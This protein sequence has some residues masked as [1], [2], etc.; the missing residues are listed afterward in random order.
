MKNKKLIII[1]LLVV[2]LA[3]A[4]SN[5]NNDKKQEEVSKNIMF[6]NVGICE[7]LKGNV[8]EI[9][10]LHSSY[11]IILSSVTTITTDLPRTENIYLVLT[12]NGK[13]Y[14]L[15]DSEEPK[16][17]NG[18]TCQVIEHDIEIDKLFLM[19]DS[20]LAMTK[21]NQIYNINIYTNGNQFTTNVTN[22]FGSV[23]DIKTIYIDGD[24]LIYVLRNNGSMYYIA[25][26]DSNKQQYSVTIDSYVKS[27][28]DNLIGS[29]NNKYAFYPVN[30]DNVIIGS[31]YSRDSLV[32]KYN[33]Y[34]FTNIESSYSENAKSSIEYAIDIDKN[35]YAKLVNDNN[36]NEYSLIINSDKINGNVQQFFGN[37]LITNS[38]IYIID[39]KEK[40]FLDEETIY[41]LNDLSTKFSNISDLTNG[42]IETMTYKTTS[43]NEYQISGIM[44]KDNGIVRYYSN[45]IQGD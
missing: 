38:S 44:L 25:L 35:I 22:R 39:T 11:K 43:K 15:I 21:D 16:Y 4:C 34:K 3:S 18:T 9:I 29:V 26:N 19:N 31:K 5:K 20:A 14:N 2:V 30:K 17:T 23:S 24:G 28:I 32:Q 13:L 42:K 40:E 12:N 45:I 1:L 7:E 33:D 6:E 10:P 27:N 37:L 8:K 41:I 36:S